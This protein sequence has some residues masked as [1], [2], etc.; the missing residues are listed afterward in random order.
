MAN[1]TFVI[2]D[3]HGDLP[4]LVAL[5]GKLPPMTTTDKIIFLGDFVDCG[6]D[7]AG[8]VKLVRQLPELTPAQVVS[9]R[10]NHEDGWLRAMDGGWPDFVMPPGNGCLQTMESFLGRPVSPLGTGFEVDDLEVLFSGSFFPADVVEW[11]KGLPYFFEDD[12]AIYVHAGLP[13]VDGRFIHPSEAE[14]KQKTALLW[15]R[16]KKFFKDYRGKLVVF[17]HT[18]TRELPPEFAA[19]T[20]EDPDDLWAGTNTVGIDT[21]CGK[22]GFLTCIELPAGTIYESRG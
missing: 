7:A 8:V 15:T 12:H 10:G 13:D 3:I 11:M 17:G 6:P 14:G 1:R 21:R 4:H 19:Y 18:A 2:G 5:L 20:P 22:G 9:L 16:D